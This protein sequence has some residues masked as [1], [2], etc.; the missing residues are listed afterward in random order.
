MARRRRRRVNETKERFWRAHL[1]DQA[2]GRLTIRDY[3]ARHGLAEPSFYAWRREIIRRDQMATREGR[4]AT[5]RAPGSG[6]RSSPGRAMNGEDRG[7]SAPS[8]GK[9]EFVRLEVRPPCE[10]APPIEFDT[11]CTGPRPDC[12]M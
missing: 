12:S 2:A 5:T 1:A 4:G 6:M 3:C 7:L 8:L 11:R 9:P 10:T